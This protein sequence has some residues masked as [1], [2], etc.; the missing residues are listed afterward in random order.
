MGL[1]VEHQNKIIDLVNGRGLYASS[2]RMNT[3]WK[4]MRKLIDD[5]ECDPNVRA[6]I[7][8]ALTDRLRELRTV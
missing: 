8:P 4:D 6:L 2:K 1:S 7:G 5:L 3:Q